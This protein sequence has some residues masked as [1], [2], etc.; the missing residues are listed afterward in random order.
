MSRFLI[1]PVVAFFLVPVLCQG[2]PPAPQ[3]PATPEGFV[4]KWTV[5]FTNG[6]RQKCEV[7]KEGKATVE[8]PL[9][10][11]PGKVVM[12][13]GSILIQYEDDRAERWTAIGNRFI[14]EHWFPASQLPT[15]TAVIGIADRVK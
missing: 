8:E 7:T 9:R 1:L 12:Q 11:S 4:G 10:S 14:V 3:A 2:D 6:V 13:G 15:G 5:E